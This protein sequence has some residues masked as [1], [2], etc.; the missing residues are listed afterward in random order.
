MMIMMNEYNI[1][2]VYQRLATPN[3]VGYHILMYYI[4]TFLMSSSSLCEYAHNHMYNRAAVADRA[5]TAH[6]R[7]GTRR[8][9][10]ILRDR[11]V[12]ARNPLCVL[13]DKLHNTAVMALCYLS[14]MRPSRRRTSCSCRRL[15]RILV[16][17]ELSLSGLGCSDSV[18]A[19]T[20]WLTARRN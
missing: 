12:P 15:Q 10:R 8:F 16:F 9:R 13:L 11:R 3:G 19:P 2:D 4:T 18:C 14:L 17:S 20:A 5:V 6:V 7:H 1:C